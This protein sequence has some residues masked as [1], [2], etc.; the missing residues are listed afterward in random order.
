MSIS[1]YLY[2][3]VIDPGHGGKDPGAVS[4]FGHEED[5]TLKISLYQLERC[6][7]LGIKAAITRTT[8]VGLEPAER[9]AKVKDL[10]AKYGFSNHL[11][12]GGGDRAEVIHSIFDD[13]KLAHRIKECLLAVGQT[14][15]KV[16]CRANSNNV[17]YYYMHRETG[18]TKM[19]IIEYCFIDNEADF[20]HFSENWQEYAEAALKG[21]CQYAGFNYTPPG[22]AADPAP[23]PASPVE[24]PEEQTKAPENTTIYTVVK[25][26]SLY[27]IAAD[28]RTTV[29]N[30]KALNGLKGDLIRIGQKL[31]VPK[32]AAA[33]SAP[34]T[35][36]PKPPAVK[37][38][39]VYFPPGCGNWSVYPTNKLPVK[40]NAIGAINPTKFGGLTYEVLGHPYSNVVT[41]KTS[42][43]DKVNIFVGDSNSKVYKK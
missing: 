15:V 4:P 21:F 27:R 22:K 2:D 28:N 7:E 13:G 35:A 38:E 25:G 14:A 18:A 5:W 39:Y 1:A 16:Y 10:K 43:W 41:I 36:A 19:N 24:A 40:K 8:D 33:T 26:D 30:I 42:N 34:K 11:N 23:T 17:D 12:A 31:Y 32:A 9:T 3:L 29:A 37:K 20:K 6:K